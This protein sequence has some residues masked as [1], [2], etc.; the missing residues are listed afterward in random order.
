VIIDP[1]SSALGENVKSMV[2]DVA[3]EN[4]GLGG[5]DGAYAAVK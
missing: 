5:L 3:D 2:V 1:T 4:Y